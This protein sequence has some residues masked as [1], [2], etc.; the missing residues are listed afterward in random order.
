MQVHRAYRV[1]RAILVHWDM[2]ALKVIQVIQDHL[3]ILVILDPKV[4]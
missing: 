1:N 3:V 2:W 4:I